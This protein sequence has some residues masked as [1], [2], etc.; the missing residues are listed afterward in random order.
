MPGLFHKLYHPEIFQGSLSKQKYF[1]GW[2]YKLVSADEQ[3]A[4]AVIPGIAIYDDT[5]HHAFIQVINGVRQTTSYH[6][7]PLEQFSADE[8]T[9]KIDIGKNH[10]SKTSVS[11]DLPEL[12]GDITLQDSIPLVSSLLSPGIMGWYSFMPSMQCYHGVVSLHHVL[13]GKTSGTAGEIEWSKG[14]G[15]IEKDW[16]T[17]FPKCWIWIHSNNFK[18]QSPASLMASVAHIPWMGRYFP[19]F[20]VVLLAGGI[21]YRFAT[22]NGSRMKCSVLEDRVVLEFR[23]GDLHLSIHAFRGPTAVLRSPLTGQMTG[24]VNESLQARVE[25][26]LSRSGQTIWESTGTSAGL[27]VAGDTTILESESWRR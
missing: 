19:G 6:R 1:E 20:I 16:G 22:Y 18:D 17:S 26:A 14:V 8:D 23:R 27:E 12:K 15:Y 13:E 25:V 4:V 24:K 11:L 3:H 10:F 7:F 2:Y 9:L 21:E 5:D